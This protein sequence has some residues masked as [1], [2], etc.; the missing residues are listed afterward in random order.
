[1]RLPGCGYQAQRGLRYEP[2][3]ASCLVARGHKFCAGAITTVANYGYLSG[4][5]FAQCPATVPLQERK[6]P[7][8]VL[9]AGFLVPM[10]LLV[11]PRPGLEPGTYGLTGGTLNASVTRMDA[12]LSPKN[13]K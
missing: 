7:T 11:A 2:P 3:G 5:V 12:H 9:I 13:A 10:R 4:F 1:M 8:I 6:K